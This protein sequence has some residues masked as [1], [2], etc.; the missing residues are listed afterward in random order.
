M[1][2]AFRCIGFVSIQS[3]DSHCDFQRCCNNFIYLSLKPNVEKKSNIQIASV[4]PSLQSIGKRAPFLP[5]HDPNT[6][7][8]WSKLPGPSRHVPCCLCSGHVCVALHAEDQR[9]EKLLK[10]DHSWYISMCS[11]LRQLFQEGSNKCDVNN[12]LSQIHFTLDQGHWQHKLKHFPT[13]PNIHNGGHKVAHRSSI[14]TAIF[15]LFLGIFQPDVSL[16]CLNHL[17]L[18]AQKI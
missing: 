10:D 11:S 3:A 6:S 15:W 7:W 16:F 17:V 5:S 2:H 18:P 4:I 9:I 12:T 8:H 14:Y 13:F 1:S